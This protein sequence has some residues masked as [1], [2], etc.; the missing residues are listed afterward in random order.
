MRELSWRL[1][2]RNGQC[3]AEEARA[4]LAAEFKP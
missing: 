3:G 1:P 4:W 2:A